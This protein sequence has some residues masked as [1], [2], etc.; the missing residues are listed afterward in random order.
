MTGTGVPTHGSSIVVAM[1]ST[2]FPLI[3]PTVSTHSS[4]A[5]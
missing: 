3:T 4:W 1:T 5:C 2:M